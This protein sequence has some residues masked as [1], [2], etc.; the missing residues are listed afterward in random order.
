MMPIRPI[1]VSLSGTCSSSSEE[2]VHSPNVTDTLRLRSET[3]GITRVGE[4]DDPANRR[5][6]ASTS[7]A[8]IP[9]YVCPPRSS[10]RSREGSSHEVLGDGYVTETSER[11]LDPSRLYTR[12]TYCH[13]GLTAK[14]LWPTGTIASRIIPHGSCTADTQACASR[15]GGDRRQPERRAGAPA[16]WGPL[17]L[18][19]LRVRC[20]FHGRRST[21]GRLRSHGKC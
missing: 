13:F 3:F 6:R 21:W 19:E 17:D 1:S 8:R 16:S 20:E 7:D 4:L 11:S 2:Q 9:T 5:G 14:G 18:S 10:R 15:V 12:T